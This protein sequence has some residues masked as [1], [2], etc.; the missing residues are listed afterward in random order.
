MIFSDT[1][2]NAIV[3]DALADVLV[4]CVA[5]ALLLAMPNSLRC[6]YVAYET[7]HLRL[8][9]KE[10]EFPRRPTQYLAG[11]VVSCVAYDYGQ[12]AEQ[13]AVLMSDVGG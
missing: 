3:S 6:C 2:A 8:T 12:W 9:M 11:K 13:C 5:H 7:A 10:A 4:Y 1:L